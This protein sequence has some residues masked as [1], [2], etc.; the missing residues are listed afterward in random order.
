LRIAR[1]PFD[2]A[3]VAEAKREIMARYGEDTEPGGP[4]ASADVFLVARDGDGSVL[5]C[6]ALRRVDVESFEIKRMYTRPSARGRG[7]ARAVLSE[8]EREAAALGA[9]RVLLETGTLQHEAIALY[10]SAGYGAIPCFGVYAGAPQSLCY[11]R[12]L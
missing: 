3:L 8:L 6:G 12:R 5:G 1:E 9:R 10:E 4:P 11:Q 2:A 7:V